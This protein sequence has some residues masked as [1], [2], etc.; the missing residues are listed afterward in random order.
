MVCGQNRGGEHGGRVPS[1]PKRL[2]GEPVRAIVGDH[3]RAPKEANNSETA[4]GQWTY[5]VVAKYVLT[6]EQDSLKTIAA[7]QATR[8]SSG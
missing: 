3:R 6:L 5:R 4:P 7:D 2:P 1:R 8:T